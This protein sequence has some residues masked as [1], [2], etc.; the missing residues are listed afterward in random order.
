[1][2]E[3]ILYNLISELLKNKKFIDAIELLEKLEC[4]SPFSVKQLSLLYRFYGQ[5]EKEIL[6]FHENTTFFLNDPYLIK[7]KKELDKNLIELLVPRKT[8]NS[9]NTFS[10]SIK[11]NIV[12]KGKL[13]FVVPSNDEYFSLLIEC[14]SSIIGC[15]EFEECPIFVANCGLNN[16]NINTLKNLNKRITVVEID[17]ILS[18]NKI[19]LSHNEK[20]L[21]ALLF[22]GFF[23]DLFSDFEYCFYMDSDAWIQDQSC[24]YDYINLAINQGIALP[25]HPFNVNVSKSSHW[26]NRKTLTLS[27]EEFVIGFPAIINCCICIKI[28]SKE[29]GDYKETLI[30]NVASLGANWGV[31]QEVF[32]YIAAKYKLQ[33]LPNE[34]AYEGKI[35]LKIEEDGSHILYSKINELIKIFHLGGG[36]MNKKRKWNYFTDVDSVF[37]HNNIHLRTSTHFFVPE[38]ENT[39]L[40]KNEL[41]KL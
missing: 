28:N 1:M 21:A 10:N 7:R 22:R 31:D 9:P 23:D 39:T 26:L 16:S 25:K 32:L 15:D 29:Y 18:K 13:C 17:G 27:Q 8:L 33:L 3:S 34:Y 40:I 35:N 20:Y 12:L 11:N 5:L 19:V 4:H 30:N 38:W 14:L 6:L 2:N 36:L 41:Y 24:I 37:Q